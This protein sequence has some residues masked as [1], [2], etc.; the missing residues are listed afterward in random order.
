[1]HED[2][3]KFRNRLSP[4]RRSYTSYYA[5]RNL[6]P[7]RRP[8]QNGWPSATGLSASHSARRCSGTP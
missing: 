6:K 5:I 3:S 4:A 7:S 1:M 8:D 2:T